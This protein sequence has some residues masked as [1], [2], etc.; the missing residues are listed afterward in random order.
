MVVWW[1]SL[2]GYHPLFFLGLHTIAWNVGDDPNLP[3]S[4]Q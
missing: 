3:V 1:K 2:E 4:F